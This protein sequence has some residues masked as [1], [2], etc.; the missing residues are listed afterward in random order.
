MNLIIVTNHNDDYIKFNKNGHTLQYGH[1][2][3]TNGYQRLPI[4]L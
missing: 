2:W 1:V 4:T 3:K